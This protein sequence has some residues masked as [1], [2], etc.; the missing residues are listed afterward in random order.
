[1][2]VQPKSFLTPR[3]VTNNL[4]LSFIQERVWQSYLWK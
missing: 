3:I 4:N 1:M 2:F